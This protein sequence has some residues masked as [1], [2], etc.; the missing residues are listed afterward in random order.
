M[1]VHA[2][3]EPSWVE[4]EALDDEGSDAQAEPSG[5]LISP[6]NALRDGVAIAAIAGLVLLGGPLLRTQ[7]LIG[8]VPPAAVVAA[9]V[10]DRRAEASVVAGAGILAG[11]VASADFSATA[12]GALAVAAGIAALL[13]WAA[14]WFL[15]ES[16]RS[17]KL[18]PA[19][20]L[21]FVVATLW[22]V[23][24]GTATLPAK[25][26]S[27]FVG[28][29][30][31]PPPITKDVADEAL[32]LIIVQRMKN[33]EDYYKA[34]VRTLDEAN[35]AFKGRD[36]LRTPTSFRPPAYYW[37]L[38]RLPFN[39][40]SI[41]YSMLVLGS[42]AAVAAYLLA[43]CFTGPP[44]ALVA[45]AGVAAWYA[46]ISTTGSVLDTEPVAGVL[47]LVTL[48]LLARWWFDPETVTLGYAAAV[49]AFLA[50]FVRELAVPFLLFGLALALL[51]ELRRTKV[52]FAWAVAGIAV[53]ALYFAHAAAVH[54]A[55]RALG[56]Q[57]NIKMGWFD[58]RGRGLL[59]LVQR[60]AAAFG[61]RP[62]AWAILLVAA[63]GAL[64]VLK[65]HR[66]LGAVLAT[67]AIGGPL[68]LTF[69]HPDGEAMTV[70]PMYWA[71]VVVPALLACVPL[72]LS[73]LSPAESAKAEP[74][75]E[76]A[77][78]V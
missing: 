8:L 36:D 28:L 19:A 66:A 41:L 62:L 22:L 59:A 34:S 45:S 78:A 42:V 72:A 23:I 31:S 70:V 71:D 12:A 65:R 6:E 73:S 74:Y 27:T 64:V 24:T 49:T 53:P 3:P 46:Y 50:V 69:L 7:P 15:D 35:K 26:G 25:D 75:D 5:P 48:A 18:M 39:G 57:P 1:E 63:V 29:L 16:P 13:A 47:G 2:E 20:A 14:R 43:R 33:G 51:P 58:A 37:L 9:L 10:S 21:A 76:V 4:D 77:K 17:V 55:V 54:A 61:T 40:V 52:W 32:F 30:A 67:C 38:S 68:A 44:L 11:L 56:P 60:L